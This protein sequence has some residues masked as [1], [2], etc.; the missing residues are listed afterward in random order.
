[1]RNR[2]KLLLSLFPLI[3]IYLPQGTPLIAGEV[4]YKETVQPF[5]DTYC[6]SC[7]GPEKQ[8]GDR[9][10]DTLAN[11]FHDSE[12]IILWQDIADLMNLGDMPPE[13]KK[14]PSARERQQVVDW[15]TGRLEIAYAEAKSTDRKTILR[16]LNRDQYNRTVR[17]LL[18][19]EDTLADPTESF[20]PDE[21]EENF[22]NIGSALITSDFLLQGYL[23]AAEAYIEQASRMGPKPKI[24]SYHFDAPFYTARNRWDGKDVAGKFQHIRKNTTD[25]DGF[26]WLEKL[27][28]GVSESGYYNL[29]FKAQAINR[30][31]PYPEQIVG[32]RKSEPLRVDVIAGSRQYGEL[33]FRTSSDKKVAGFVIADEAPEWYE[34]RIWLDEG[35]QP[36]LTFP[37]GPNRVKPI[38]KT[39]VRNYPEHFQEFIHNWTVPGDGVYPYPIEEAEQRRID[40]VA[41]KIATEVGDVLTTDGTSNKFNRRDGWAAFYRGYEGPRIRVFEIDLQGPFY[42]SWP[43]PSYQALFGEFKPTMGNARAILHRFASDAFRRP[44]SDDKLDVLHGLVKNEH[45]SGASAFEALKIGFRA[46]LCSPDF[47]YLHEPEGTLD[48]YALASRL[49]YFLWSNRPDKELLDTAA[50]GSLTDSK[51]L[52]R[53][54]LRLLA[55]ERS[56]AFTNTFTSRWLELYKL[57]TM[58]PSYKEFTNYYVDGLEEAMKT[59]TQTFF[60]HVLQDNLPLRTFLDSD[61]TFVNGGLARLYGIEGINGADF[62]KVSLESN[63]RRGGLMGH[64]SILTASANGIDTS[65]VIRGIWVLENI[66]GTPPSPPPP[67]V[68]PLEP[69]IRGATTIRDQLDKHREVETCYECHRKIDPLGFA[70]ENYDPIGGWRDSYP[71]GQQEGPLIDASGELP[72]GEHFSGI[73]EFKEALANREDQFVRCLTEKLLAYSMGRTLEYTDRPEVDQI[74]EKT[75]DSGTGLQDLVLAIV[76]SEAFRTK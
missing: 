2:T 68:E 6:I 17:D 69:D 42:E 58:P 8:K 76:E 39:L 34:A 44:V 40:A 22:N 20:P 32:T 19:L 57:G 35:Y 38:R 52:Q 71:R 41:K 27:E 66:L 60:R 1:M 70:L 13:E 37:N 14:Q 24:E 63:P 16:R 72:N 15:I 47:L 30:V 29:R 3:G 51:V 10:Y 31:Y 74:I 65:P 9:R 11:D 53:Q 43:S 54:T 26:L 28:Q 23:D 73:R 67:D 21:T 50:D 25:Q 46:V 45:E 5:L 33:E 36:R 7:H 49:S 75:L 12:S 48:S 4:F 61:F 56:K 55:D 64:A 62:R 59:E 18:K